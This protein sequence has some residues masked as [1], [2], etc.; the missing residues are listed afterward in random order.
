MLRISNVKAPLELPVSMLIEGLAREI[1]YNGRFKSWKITKKAL[2][3]RSKANIHYVYSIDVEVDDEQAFLKTTDYSFVEQVKAEELRRFQLKKA[4]SAARPVVV[5]SGPAGMFAGIALA[6]AGLQP[7]IL[8]RGAPVP[9]RQKDIMAFWK[10]AELKEDSN[11]QFGEGGAGTFSDGKLMSGIKKDIYTSKVL[12]ELIAAGAPEEIGYLAK[13]HIGTDKLAAAVQKIRAKIESLGG[14]YRFYNRVEDLLVKD[15]RLQGLKIRNEKGEIYE[16]SADKVILAIGH[17]ARDTFEMLYK[18]Q[19]Q[20]Q[21]KPF[22]IGV[23]VEHRQSLINKSQYGKFS[24]QLGAADY[25]LAYHGKNGRS[26]YTFCMCPGGV[27]VAAASEKG[28][29]VTNGMS[30]FARDKINANSALLVG[31]APEDFGGGHPLQGMY[32]QRQLEEK[33]FRLGGNNYKAPAQL[34]KDFLLGK[35]SKALGDV[36]PSYRP[37]VSLGNLQELL[38]SYVTETMK[39]AILEMNKRLNGFACPDAVLTGIES[40]SS[41]PIRIVRN[42]NMQSNIK[43]LYPCGE[44]AGYAGGILS[45]AADG[46]KC[47][48]KLVESLS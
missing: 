18:N 21:Q 32:W 6:E 24:S 45:A 2:D 38:P 23:R 33:A 44:G 10:N 14:E 36:F 16:L 19:I 5:G 7:I 27:V 30:E 29:V 37:G 9:Q 39:T 15:E 48:E 42:E 35:E 47:A 12:Q 11:V 8:E 4:V 13:P 43:G 26:A 41:S 3:A 46:L 34:L 28:R 25:K 17:S 22:S 1:G 40:R 20:I 31:V